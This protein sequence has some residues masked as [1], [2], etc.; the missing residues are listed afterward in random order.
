MEIKKIVTNVSLD[1]V[2]GF[3]Y[4]FV[5]FVFEFFYS[6]TKKMPNNLSESEQPSPPWK[7]VNR[8]KARRRRDNR[9]RRLIEE[10]NYWPF[11]LEDKR[12]GKLACPCCDYRTHRTIVE[13]PIKGPLFTRVHGCARCCS[14]INLTRAF[15]PGYVEPLPESRLHFYPPYE[16]Y[17]PPHPLL[18]FLPP[19]PH[20][21]LFSR[22]PFFCLTYDANRGVFV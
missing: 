10:K 4:L 19:G 11:R 1:I 20:P 16:P 2:L 3:S 15:P 12:Q 14:Y 6:E 8:N 9:R 21:L 17:P 7:I 22:L 5:F 13:L 18:P